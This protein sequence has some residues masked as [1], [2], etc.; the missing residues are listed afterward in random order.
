MT[1]A[2]TDAMT[3]P[4]ARAGAAD[5]LVPDTEAPPRVDPD[6]PGSEPAP[7]EAEPGPVAAT[8]PFTEAWGAR[9]EDS[10]ETPDRGT[11]APGSDDG[12]GTPPPGWFRR[13]LDRFLGMPF[14]SY[15]TLVIVGLCV[16]FVFWML[17]PAYIFS[18]T[19]PAGGDMGAHVWAPAYLRDH[20]LT[21]GRF[22][23]WTPD[24]YAGFPAFQ[25]YMIVPSFAIAMLS[26]VIPYG[27]A[28][29]LVAVS[30]CVSLPFCA[31]FFGRM[32]RLPFPAPPLLAVAATFFLFDRSFSIYGGNIP[33]TLAGEF[34]FSISLSF[35]LLYLGVLARGLETGKLRGWAAV[36]LALTG[37]CHLIPFI[38]VLVCT[39]LWFVVRPGIGQLKYLITFG[40][41][42]LLLTAFWMLP[43]YGR[44]GYMNDM[45]WEKIERYRDYLWDRD[46]LDPQLVNVP[47]LKWVI[48]FAAVG[49]L[50]SLVYRRRAG[51]FL[52]L[53]AGT[54]ALGFIYAP[55]GRLWNARLL[56]FYYLSLY[57][58]A[59]VGIAELGRLLSALFA[60]D[61][62]K[63][64]RSV[65]AATPIICTLLVGGMLL[66]SLQ[67]M[68]GGSI[69]AAG[70][71][72][73]GPFSTTDRSFV[74]SWAKWNFEGYEGSQTNANGQTQYLKSYP[75]YYGIV[76]AM[77]NLGQTNGC[78]RAMWE[79]EEQHDRYGTPMALMLLPFWTDGCIGSMEGLY[80]EASSTTP[81][82]FLNQD[83]LSY[84][85]SNAQRDLPYGAGPPTQAE[86]DLG[87]SHLQM[88]AV[89]Y[90]MAINDATKVQAQKNPNLVQLT[91]SGPWTVYE[92][93]D[94]NL[95]VPLQ[96][97]PAV[98]TGQ[99]H[100]GRAWQDTSVCWY[101]N[102][103]NWDVV[104]T[105]TGPDNWQRLQKTVNK[106]TDK[107]LTPA[108]KCEPE[109]GWGWYDDTGGPQVKPEK[110]VTVT[111]VVT[112]DDTISFD[113][114]EPGV[115]V[116]VKASY[117]PN[118]KVSGADGPY[119][120]TPNFMVVVPTSNHVEL[121]YGYTGLDLF[122]ILLTLIGIA[123]L[124][125]LFR[126]KPVRI[127]PPRRFWGKAERPDLYPVASPDLRFDPI[128]DQNAEAAL[129][130]IV[131]LAPHEVD[132]LDARTSAD[133]WTTP[134]D[135]VIG[136]EPPYKAEPSPGD[137]GTEPLS[138]RGPEPDAER[139]QAFAP[140]TAEE[141]VVPNLTDLA[142][143]P[144]PAT[145]PATPDVAPSSGPSASSGSSASSAPGG[146]T[147]PSGPGTASGPGA[148][149]GPNGSSDGGA[150]SPP[151]SEPSPT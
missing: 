127:K 35:A 59:A 14:E 84:G 116:L 12:D 38:F 42:A 77:K 19:T 79:H 125:Y 63:P 7:P 150:T 86:F 111:N 92:V 51:L 117:F 72:K 107:T 25:F 114:S 56:P 57:L 97:E 80:F 149:S 33:S 139:N 110:N 18:D 87:I 113:V 16:G 122:A 41:I 43:F 10:T 85:P 68:P 58:L 83:E 126:A 69:D 148:P 81:Y 31:Y 61:V 143:V 13:Q 28:F 120:A 124:V 109:A 108:E 37:L 5:T 129:A 46:K 71:Y 50:L 60:R 106:E 66:M 137:A 9:A 4:D 54:F 104:L 40:P 130:S 89:K 138:G 15:I 75:E 47:D 112:S 101:M 11:P 119:R 121:H 64:M 32:A 2:M 135:S 20:L 99:E 102:Q 26:L 48:A 128:F 105:D 141:P 82:H 93:K 94:A 70:A 147:A 52:A 8:S 95:V 45:G 133:V 6:Q 140:P 67:R 88:M 118:W 36:L 136:A 76:T 100:T 1:D 22:S 90:Y 74:D 30:G 115:P 103:D 21:K 146:S 98:I 24:W 34:A 134:L 53:V 62:N 131:P 17:H 144:A 151:G 65:A 27:V 49:L 91:Q 145:D 23:G 78:G 44:S 39:G 142:D 29:K 96:N 123:G 132:A 73:W 55:Q 3:D